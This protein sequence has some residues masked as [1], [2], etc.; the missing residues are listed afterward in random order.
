MVSPGGQYA[1]IKYL[2]TSE[3]SKNV[4]T[5]LT[6]NMIAQLIPLLITPIL[7]RLFSV[8]EFGVFALYSSIATFFMVIAAGRYETAILLPK[9]DK[10]AVNI[11]ALSF[12]ILTGLSLLLTAVVLIFPIANLFDTP[13][14]STIMIFLPLTI[15][16][17]AAYRTLTFWSNRK[18]RFRATS[19]SSV[20]QATSRAGINLF[21]GMYAGGYWEV[22]HSKGF[23][24]ALFSAKGG[25]LHGVRVWGMNSL[26]VGSILGYAFGTIQF[27][28]TFI[29]KDR[30]LLKEINGASMR[31][32]AKEHD[33][34]PKINA[35][36]ALV[37]EIKNSGVTFVVSYMFSEVVLGLYSMTIRVLTLPLTMIGSAF[38]QV[39][40]QRAAEMY[41]NKEKME[42]LMHATVRRLS[43]LA[44]PIFLP[45]VFFGPD[46]F[47]IILG[48]DYRISGEFARI[49]TPW[50]FL[51]FVVSPVV[52]VTVVV[53]KQKELF[54]VALVGNS[55][56]LGSI[57][58]G[59]FFFHKL[60]YGFMLLSLLEI[61]F[62]IWLYKWVFAL[63]KK[64]DASHVTSTET[65][66]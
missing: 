13:E 39:F 28:R 42:P 43:F 2:P 1:M 58:I 35:V 15:F 36:H 48:D 62:Y 32:L 17:G 25:M 61:I 40:I 14:L 8:E 56:I 59:G 4:I 45:I 53:G 33:K 50:L 30:S 66:Q 21:G 11:L 12:L 24:K 26:V 5:M 63:A 3:F 9:E 47:G 10:D 54:G 38:A 7:S 22:G 57:F 37:D 16:F 55:I 64:A 29:S 20:T 49:L 18:K 52:Q 27:V 41:A 51:N 44:L 23:F 6:G 19:I 34:F 46:L 60:E 31:R 65:E